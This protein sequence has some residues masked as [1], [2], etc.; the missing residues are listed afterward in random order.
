MVPLILPT[1]VF[2]NESKLTESVR[3]SAGCAL[4][5]VV[6]VVT[7][8][9]MAL[10]LVVKSALSFSTSALELNAWMA[11]SKV[12]VALLIAPNTLWK[13]ARSRLLADGAAKAAPMKANEK[14]VE[15]RMFA[16]VVV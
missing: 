14:M 1:S 7:A 3:L 4:T 5:V 11:V 10:D 12:T 9:T 13:V 16:I 15:T 8:V 2:D 6:P